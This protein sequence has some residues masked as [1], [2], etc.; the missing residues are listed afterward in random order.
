MVL[1]DIREHESA[2]AGISSRCGRAK[3]LSDQYSSRARER[4]RSSP[5][6]RAVTGSRWNNFQDLV[7]RMKAAKLAAFVGMGLSMSGEAHEQRG[8]AN[9]PRRR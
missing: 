1:V 5:G 7:N 8:S 2:E 4:Q 9:A 6:S 3:I